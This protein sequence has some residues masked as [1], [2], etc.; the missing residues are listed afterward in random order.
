MEPAVDFANLDTVLLDM[1]GT[2]LDLSFDNFFWQQLIPAQYALEHGHDEA[3][4]RERVFDMYRRRLGTLDWYCLDHWSEELGIDIVALKRRHLERVGF[5]PG[6]PEFLA[7]LRER[8]LRSVIATNAHGTTLELK[9]SVTGLAHLVDDVH[10]SHDYGAPK[11]NVV[12]WQQ[13]QR[14]VGFDPRRALFIDDNLTV[15]AAARSFGIEGLLAVRQPDST[16]APHTVEEFAA[17]DGVR[18]LT[19]SLRG[20][21]EADREGG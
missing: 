1:D 16:Q 12:F 10:S 8:G 7:A 14:R 2:L 20:E 3:D 9:L 13:F 17:V 18:D 6:V 15:L 5:L 11:E 19:P 21:A 4:A